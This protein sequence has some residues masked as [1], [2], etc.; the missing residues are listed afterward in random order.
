MS[1]SSI[2]SGSS[3]LGIGLS[4]AATEERKCWV[5]AARLFDDAT[6]RLIRKRRGEEVSW[7]WSP[8]SLSSMQFMCGSGVLK[9]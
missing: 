6:R 8:S 5:G 3:M 7:W 9:S 2:G 1:S 4:A